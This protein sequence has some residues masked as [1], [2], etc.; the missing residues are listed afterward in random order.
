LPHDRIAALKAWDHGKMDGFNQS[1]A[2]D[3]YAYTQLH[4]EQLP[5]Y[6]HWAKENVLAD[7]FFAS[8]NGPSFPNHMFTIAAQSGGAADNPASPTGPRGPY[9][10]WG[11]DAPDTELV[12]VQDPEGDW[13]QVPPCFH[14]KTIGDELDRKGI[15]WTYYG[16]PPVP[17]DD[18][19]HS[20]YIFSAYASFARYRNHP[21]RWDEH[22]F[23]V[24]QVVDDIDK[25]ILAPVTWITPRY[26]LSEHPEYNFCYGENWSTEVIDAVMRSP[27]W[28]DTAIFLTWDDWGGFYDHVQP[29]RVDRNGYGLRVPGLVISPYARRGFID[30]QTLSFDAYVKFIEDDF[31]RGKRLDPK[32]AGGPDPRPTVREKAKILGDLR[33]DFN[34]SQK[35]RRPLILP[36]HPKSS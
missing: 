28:K 25:G 13:H 33:K 7:N 5:N 6:W 26:A 19:G 24:D 8:V 1:V 4:P 2:A 23:N 35:P 30:H 31:L 11:C 20:G 15:P 3:L 34:F 22:I 9:K 10:T 12:R 36:L 14:F 17:W 21:R 16:A 27:M 32:T 18:P 29:P